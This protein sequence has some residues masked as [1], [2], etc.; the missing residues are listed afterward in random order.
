MGDR[1]I[2]LCFINHARV[3]ERIIIIISV[4]ALHLSSVRNHCIMQ[5]IGALSITMLLLVVRKVPGSEQSLSSTPTTDESMEQ[6]L[7]YFN[8]D[9][10]IGDRS[11]S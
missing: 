8:F 10:F 5:C 2:M 3:F 1:L 7:S 4:T 11:R 6:P 9:Y